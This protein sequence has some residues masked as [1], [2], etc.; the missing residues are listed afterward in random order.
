MIIEKSEIAKELKKLKSLTPSNKTDEVN[1][2]LFK[3]NMLVANNFEMT[4]TA[5]LPV[6]TNE[7]FVIPMKAI[8]L[9]ENSPSSKIEITEK[10]NRLCVKSK[11]GKSTF[12]TFGIDKFPPCDIADLSEQIAAFA[13]DGETVADAISKVL[14]ACGVNAARPVMNGILLQS[15][16]ETLD[17]VACDGYRLAWNQIPYTGNIKAVIPKGT[18]QKI[19]SFGLNGSIKLYAI[20]NK[21]AAFKTEK[22]TL[23]TQ[24]LEGDYINFTTFFKEDGYNTKATV[25]RTELLESVARSVIC[26]NEK[27]ATKMILESTEDGKL[28][29]SLKNEIADFRETITVYNDF[30]AS[31]KSAFNPRY[32]IECLKASDEDNIDILYKNSEKGIILLDGELKQL[33]LPMRM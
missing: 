23:Y 22:Y 29:V 2:V 11:C 17:I 4:A 8:E 21:K 6:E 27:Y 15:N 16:G 9:I 25:K 10:N 19:L 1:G 5:K 7:A 28:S 31:V 32:L 14:Y 3:D 30:N 12:A 20:D 26:A 33:V 13:Y 18:I 24:L